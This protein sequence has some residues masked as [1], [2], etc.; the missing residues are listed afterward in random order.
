MD[1]R[2]RFSIPPG[3]YLLNHSAGALPNSAEVAAAGFFA[4]WREQGGDAWD[5]WLGMVD[6]WRAALAALL[7]GRPAEWCP[8]PS[9]TAGI[10]KLL[11][12]VEPRPGRGRILIS[13]LDFPSVGFA[14]QQLRRRGWQVDFLE[15]DEQRY[16]PLERWDVALTPGTDWVLVTHSIYGNSW[17]NQAGEIVALAKSRGIRVIVDVAQSAGVVPIDVAAW[18]SEAVAG[19]CIKWSCGGPGAGFLWT[20]PAFV[21]STEPEDV[22]WFSHENPF[23]FEIAN[24]RYAPDGRRFWGGTPGVLPFVVAS[25]GLK[26]LKEIGVDTIRAHNQALTRRLLDAANA[27]GIPVAT[28]DDDARRGG[29]VILDFP[30]PAKT[31]DRL[32]SAGIRCDQRPGFGVR[33]SPHIFNTDSEIETVCELLSSM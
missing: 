16:F 24:F 2:G 23:E 8:Q 30:D 33:F 22:G 11:H 25:E 9:V 32:Q 13:R 28:P 21:K 26:L 18:D 10:V 12:G 4:L 3:I 5:G 1:V 17:L 31:V 27:K 20:N 15:P 29:T 19:S 7:G 14:L 6:D